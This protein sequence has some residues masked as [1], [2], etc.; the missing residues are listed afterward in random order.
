MIHELWD[1]DN[2]VYR[3]C[4]MALKYEDYDQPVT[5]VSD[6]LEGLKCCTGGLS[7]S[8]EEDGRSVH[9]KTLVEE[10]GEE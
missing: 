3:K 1:L 9:L 8:D 7:L 6:T 5:K 2:T 4:I 10:D